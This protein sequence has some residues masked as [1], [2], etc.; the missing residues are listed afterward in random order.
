MSFVH[1][2]THS[3]YSLLDGLS[4]I[5]ELIA[6][7]KELGMGAIAIT[8]HGVMYGA[9]EFYQKAKKAGIKPIIGVEAYVA[10]SMYDKRPGADG[11]NYYHLILLA[12]NTVGYKNLIKLTTAAHLDG[13]YYKPR[14]DKN[15]LRQHAKGLI[16]LSACLGGEISRAL[17]SGQ[18]EKAK[19]IALQ[20]HDIF[21]KGNFFLEI[22]RHPNLEG[23]AM[24][25]EK[26]AVLSQATNIPLV[27]TQD[28]HYLRSEDS[29]AH[30]VLLAIQ[31]GSQTDDKDRLSMR[32]DD[33]SVLSP[34]HMAE[35]FKDIPDALANTI[36]IAD[37]CNV[38]IPL[39]TIQ[40]PAFPLPEGKDAND[41]LRELAHDGLVRRYGGQTTE[42]IRKRLDYEL[43]VIKTTGF[44]SYFLIV[45]DLVNWAKQQGI[46]VGPGR[47]SAA[48]SL[49]TYL[50][51]ITNVDPIKYNLLFER[52]LNPARVSQP[53]IDIDFDD[54]RRDEVFDYVR[55]KYGRD[56]FAQIIT[57]GT[58]AARGGIRDA[59]RA[60]GYSYEQCDR[61]AKL[62]PFNPQQGEKSGYLKRCIEEVDELKQLYR[63]NADVKKLIDAAVSLE[64]VARHSSTHACA[65]VISPQPLTDYLPLQRDTKGGNVITQYEMHA[66]EDLGLLK[67]D[68]LGL[69][70]LTI[71]QNALNL[72]KQD[73]GIAINIDDIPLNDKKAF[74]VFKKAQTTGVFQLE[75]S[76]IKRY[77]KEL[78]PTEIED[79]IAMISLYRPGPMELIPEYIA[80][81]H[82]KKSVAYLHPTLEPVLKNTYGIMVYQEQ[83]I[84]AVQV[85][86]GFTLAEADVLR[87]A[88][89]KKIKKLLGEQEDKFKKGA[90]RVGTPKDIANKFWELVE[91]FNRYAFNRCLTGDARIMDYDTG[92][93][94]RM[95]AMAHGTHNVRRV[96]SLDEQYK[97]KPALVKS[98]FRNGVKKVFSVRTKSGRCIK[99]TSNHPFRGIHGWTQL[100]DLE[101]GNVIAVPRTLEV[102]ATD[103]IS[104][105]KLAVLGYLLAEGNLC[106]PHGVYYYAKEK[107]E[108][109]DYIQ[110]LEQ[111][112]NTRAVVNEKRISA[113][114][115]YSR[116]I[117][118]SQPCAAVVFIESLGLKY[119]KAT[120]KYFPDFVFRLSLDKLALLIG[121]MFQGD[122]CINLKRVDPQIFYASS[123]PQ[124]ISELQHLLLRFGI[125]STIHRKQFKYRGML[126]PG[127]TLSISR[128]DNIKKF[129]ATFS[130]YFVGQKAVAC[131]T[132]LI[133]HPILNGTLKTWAARGSSDV[134]PVELIR[135]TLRDA[136]LAEYAGY[137]AFAREAGVSERLL[138]V[139]VR[140]KG[141][142]RETVQHIVEYLD[143]TTLEM[144][145][146][147]QVLWDEIKEIQEIDF[148]PTYD[149]EIEGTHNYVVNDIIVHNSHAACYAMLSY[150][151]AYLK[152]NYPIEFMAALMNSD[153]GDIERIAFL[154]DECRSMDIEVLPPHINES[155]A[156]FAVVPDNKIRFGLAAIKNVGINVVDA[157]I[158][159]RQANGPFR[160]AEEVVSRVQSKDL[161]KK[162]LESLIKCGALD[163]CGERTAM[164]ASVDELLS[165]ARESQKQASMGQAS[166]FGGDGNT[167][168]PAIRLKDVP[169]ARRSEK[170][171]WEK[172]LLGLFISDHPLRDYRPQHKDVISIREALTK[173]TSVSVSGMVVKVQKILTKTGKPM[174]FS[175]IEDMTSKIELVVFPTVLEQYPTA[176]V[177][178]NI[179]VVSGRLNDRDGMPKLLC[180]D[181]KSVTTLA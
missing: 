47:G 77:L 170:L 157:I 13:F 20:Y 21:G 141:Y 67:M 96:L 17:L 58:I 113:P 106:H 85:L 83:L 43:D 159:E 69:A 66:V 154:I 52:F 11:K 134:I 38:E 88:V 41:Y 36:L 116:R 71:I 76:G 37:R 32:S 92:A 100:C 27:A 130:P 78:K 102:H 129:I 162:S 2:H 49:V 167:A 93:M 133:T 168:L 48:G 101:V 136:V 45:Q 152:S 112:E 139:D 1:L 42:E 131:N 30:D 46:I 82:G 44:A 165:Y 19:S 59:G 108:R 68:F 63:T 51:N 65:V 53:D 80:R 97:L 163:A 7:T 120:E 84:R 169:P 144:F 137:A 178:N 9:I 175:W 121:K 179:V 16:G 109:D 94:I 56:H 128:W 111:F 173:K 172:E 55:E 4:K 164:L 87:K 79:I 22:Q 62:I 123:S 138:L 98:V 86:A 147:S 12:E 39:G 132:I 143:D 174:L 151:T 149:L 140:K 181:V 115:V 75:S 26:L 74:Q 70:N 125:L 60:L 29:Q 153:S 15:L 171:L 91:P 177:E 145:S 23:Q 104:D 135:S 107:T 3:H 89:G 119:K 110:Y 61:I 156:G 72:I 6:R 28:A 18:D 35:L 57:F 50:L 54:A 118:L 127:Y 124:L 160:T 24:V 95:D 14:I 117:D 99:V 81:K 142:L 166:L 155:M 105:F 64:G 40:L 176:F 5:D 31:T 33:F 90:E 126:K 103:D 114:S 10:D 122:G 34:E 146:T 25:A 150:Q 180:D 148:E 73:H 161:N 158:K 8:D